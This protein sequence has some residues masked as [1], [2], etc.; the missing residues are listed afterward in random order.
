MNK[1]KCLKKPLG[2]PGTLKHDTPGTHRHR[3]FHEQLC[4]FVQPWHDDKPHAGGMPQLVRDST[5]PKFSCAFQAWQTEPIYVC[6]CKPHFRLWSST[7]D[8]DTP[9]VRWEGSY[10]CCFGCDCCSRVLLGHC[11]ANLTPQTHTQT[12]RHI[13]IQ[14]RIHRNAHMHTCTHRNTQEHT[15]TQIH[16]HRKHTTHTRAT[17]TPTQT[18]SPLRLRSL[19]RAAKACMGTHTR[20]HA[21]K[22]TTHARAHA[23]THTTPHTF[24]LLRPPAGT[25]PLCVSRSRQRHAWG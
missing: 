3:R 5:R 19:V 8:T 1:G 14:N 15:H 7:C 13:H 25:S 10:A 22:H 9:A 4:R 18:L 21:H 24:V 11:I 12:H 23:H 2:H 6:N 16:T 17:H 20:T